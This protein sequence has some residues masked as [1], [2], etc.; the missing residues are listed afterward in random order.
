MMIACS[1][2]GQL[3]NRLFH[4]SHFIA[5]SLENRLELRYPFFEE[6]VGL[7][8]KNL[9]D[10]LAKDNIYI[11]TPLV[12]KYSLHLI[13]RIIPKP[14]QSTPFYQVIRSQN[15]IDLNNPIIIR[16]AKSKTVLAFGWLFR[17]PENFQKWESKLRALFAFPP[18][19]NL[20]TMQKI[21]QFKKPRAN[22]IVVGVHIRRGDYEHYL[23][24]KYFY[25]N[26]VY[27]E[28]MQQIEA[29]L[30]KHGEQ[31]VFLISSNDRKLLSSSALFAK[32]N[33]HILDGNEVEDLCALS[34][35]DYIIGPPSSFTLWASFMGKAPL[36]FIKSKDHL[37][38]ANLFHINCG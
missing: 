16:N 35:C 26:E 33:I 10:D 7:F 13:A 5:N 29:L 17:D 22:P 11:N 12:I 31:I 24:G 34:Y 2:E 38:D 30:S 15:T 1:K 9:I 4:F 27:L 14:L 37:I 6:Y 18:E 28:K 19:I 36:Q 20:A 23:N 21:A 25:A 8:N 3:C 32:S